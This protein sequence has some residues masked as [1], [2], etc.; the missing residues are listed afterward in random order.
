[1]AEDQLREQHLGHVI[2]PQQVVERLGRLDDVLASNNPTLGNLELSLHIDRIECYSDGRVVMRTCKLGVLADVGPLLTENMEIAGEAPIK[3]SS[4]RVRPRRRARLRT[5][6][7][8]DHRDD[9]KAAAYMAADP[10]RF[11][12]LPDK[13]FWSDQF[14]MPDS[15]TSWAA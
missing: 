10:D 3:E 8:G 5:D 4:E 2:D 14:Q 12:G 15:P 1:M 6:G 7:H 13:W 11:D 9:L